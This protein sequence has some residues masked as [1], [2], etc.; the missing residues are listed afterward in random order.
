M[1][2]FMYIFTLY[3]DGQK[4]TYCISSSQ[5]LWDKNW[6]F[7][8]K[9]KIK[10]IEN[11]QYTKKSNEISS[12]KIIQL[13]NNLYNTFKRLCQTIYKKKSHNHLLL[14]ENEE[15]ALLTYKNISQYRS[16][17]ITE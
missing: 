11:K 13:N 6:S 15:N 4:R 16:K 17:I 8:D 10:H 3:D 7:I 9:Y 14:L 1:G 12:T 5:D 2:E